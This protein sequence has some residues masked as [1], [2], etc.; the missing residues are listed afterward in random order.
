MGDVVN[1]NKKRKARARS[2]RR[3]QAAANSI[4]AGITPAELRRQRAETQRS[5]RLL[6]GSKL[7]RSKPEE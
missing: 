7:E 6:D 2:T 5:Q 3:K 1:L 4:R